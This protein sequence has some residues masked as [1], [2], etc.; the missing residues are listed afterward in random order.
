MKDYPI[1]IFWSANDASYVADIP[2]RSPCTGLGET[3]ERALAEVMLAREAW[4]ETAR[5]NGLASAVAL[6]RLDALRGGDG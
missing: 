2:D 3:P 4:I 6:S 1:N 5:E